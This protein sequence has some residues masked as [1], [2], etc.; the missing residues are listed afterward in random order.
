[1]NEE[2]ILLR[3]LLDKYEKSAH[4]R[5]TS[6][7][8]RRVLLKLG[9]RSRDLTDYD[10]ENSDARE[11]IHQ[12]VFSLKKEGLI[13]YSWEKFET[14]NILSEVWLILGRVDDAY[15]RSGRI[16]RKE[17]VLWTADRIHEQ[18]GASGKASVP[19]NW[20]A[21]TLLA[22]EEKIRRTYELPSYLS[23]DQ[24]ITAD[25]LKCMEALARPEAA[26]VSLRVMSL[27][28]FHDS[29]RLEKDLLSRVKTFTRRNHPDFSS[30]PPE[31]S[32]SEE[33][34]LGAL[35]IYRNP[36]IYEF[37][38]PI[39]I[40]LRTSGSRD[41]TIDFSAFEKGGALHSSNVSGI[42]RVNGERIHT[43]L[44]IENRTN[45]EEYITNKRD[46]AELVIYHGGF[47]NPS[48]SAFFRK[49]LT[50]VGPE[51]PVRHWGDIDL[52]GMRIFLQI[53]KDIAPNLIPQHMDLGTLLEMRDY[54]V[55][56]GT[57]Y[58]KMLLSARKEIE[59]EIFYDLIDGMLENRIRLEQEAFLA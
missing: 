45:Y 37:C 14:G 57:E 6:Q 53:R 49:L 41:M 55:P 24:E 27:S 42:V 29:K 1:M 54:A 51:V 35:N 25:F 4:Y 43:V 44:F 34:L 47:H 56:F 32:L 38:G 26:A 46:P 39:G 19:D 8:G 9:S 10:I 23:D 7:S 22:A 28:L 21:G 13:D 12:A 48:K 59:F 5:E 40:T 30:I 3:S 18:F 52:G 33:E 11:R 15:R 31:E 16:P 17:Q 2:S 58:G 20:I 50:G 36:E